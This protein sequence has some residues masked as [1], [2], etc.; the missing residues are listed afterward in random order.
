MQNQYHVLV[1]KEIW[2][3]I[4]LP[5]GHKAI[6]SKWVFRVKLLFDRA[7]DN[8]KISIVAKGFL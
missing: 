4:P 1:S 6:P 7:L 8:Y 5:Q 2:K 3:L